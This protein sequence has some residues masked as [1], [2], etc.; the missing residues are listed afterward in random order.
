MQAELQE[1]ILEEEATTQFVCTWLDRDLLLP[2]R[3]K[4]GFATETWSRLHPDQWM[5][6]ATGRGSSAES[7]TAQNRMQLTKKHVS[8]RVLGQLE[9]VQITGHVGLPVLFLLLTKMKACTG[10]GGSL[11]G[12]DLQMEP[13]TQEAGRASAPPVLFGTD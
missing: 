11:G 2:W 6:R 1:R 13:A 3:E 12:P 4:P 5:P 10:P 9:V 7:P 8:S